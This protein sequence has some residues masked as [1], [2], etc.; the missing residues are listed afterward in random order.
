VFRAISFGCNRLDK[1]IRAG[2]GR[3]SGV[4]TDSI[5]GKLLFFAA[6]NANSKAINT[7]LIANRSNLPAR[8]TGNRALFTNRETMESTCRAD[9]ANLRAHTIGMP[10]PIYNHEVYRQ[11]Q[12]TIITNL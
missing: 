10:T 2:T 7:S 5:R 12:I 8:T 6:I 4:G 9:I 1:A 3:Q 11:S